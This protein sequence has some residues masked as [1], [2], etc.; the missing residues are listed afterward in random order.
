[1]SCLRP[2]KRYALSYMC[3]SPG[4]DCVAGESTF[5]C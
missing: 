3:L 5:G 1:M 2:I 4:N